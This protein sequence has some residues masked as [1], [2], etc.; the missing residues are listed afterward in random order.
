MILKIKQIIEGY[1]SWIKF[2]L[3]KSYREEIKLEAKRRIK[4]CEECPFFWKYVRNCMICGCFMDVKVK[5][6][7]KLDENNKSINGCLEKKW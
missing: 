7:F 6:K 1:Y 4:I 2:H 5:M 3:C